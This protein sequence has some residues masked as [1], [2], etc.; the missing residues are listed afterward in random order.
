M[1]DI[2]PRATTADKQINLAQLAAELGVSLSGS[3][4]EVV[5][6]DS[7]TVTQAQLVA[8]IAAHVVDP[9]FGMTDEARQFFALRVKARAVWAGTDTFTPAQIQKFL[10]GL[11]L[12]EGR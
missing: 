6:A 2:R 4:L 11:V 1:T 9:R 5:V 10:A 3:G 12:R 8:A 7:Q